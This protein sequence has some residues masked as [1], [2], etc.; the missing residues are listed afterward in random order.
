MTYRRFP[1]DAIAV[2]REENLPEAAHHKSEQAYPADK[3]RG[4]E[5]IL[6][7]RWQR[8]VFILG[9]AGAVVLGFAFTM[10]TWWT[11]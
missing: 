1:K 4:G 6:R 8:V 7:K 3:A 9:L 11:R 5:V 10:I 2:R